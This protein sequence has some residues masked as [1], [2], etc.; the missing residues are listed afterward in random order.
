MVSSAA[1]HEPAAGPPP[2]PIELCLEELGPPEVATPF[3]RCVALPSRGPGLALGHDGAVRWQ[4]AEP[5]ACQFAVTEEGELVMWRPADAPD[6]LVV[7]AG[8]SLRAPLGKPVLLLDEDELELAGRRV[9]V[10][11]HGITSSV[12]APVRLGLRQ[13]V[14]AVALSGA[15]GLGAMALGCRSQDA[16]P[17][18]Q[19]IVTS[20]ASD[21]NGS[22][23]PSAL[24]A[25]S[26]AEAP[27][28]LPSATAA[29]TASA[30]SSGSA[31]TDAGVAPSASAPSSGAPGKKPPV[32]VRKFTPE[33]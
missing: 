13:Q 24:D 2:Q 33:I 17:G 28:P 26:D 19:P 5:L 1:E 9:R 14:A 8:R 16:P 6:V 3:V 29:A 23:R 31:Q 15:V 27:A 21:T 30:A 22:D 12:H 4:S 11:V 18:P 32:K 20:A 10:H 7:R 25:R